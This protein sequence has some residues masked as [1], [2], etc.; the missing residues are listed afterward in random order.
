VLLNIAATD[1]H[2]GDRVFYPQHGVA[3]VVDR[4]EQE[5]GGTR[6]DFWV[7]KLVSG[8]RMF[9]PADNLDDSGIRPLVSRDRAQALL[10]RL[11]TEPE[12]E[13]TSG[14]KER[15]QLYSDKLKTSAPEDY[16]DV[17]H[18]LLHRGESK[19]LSSSE[20]RT[21]NTAR[22]YFATE[23]GTVLELNSEQ[24]RTILES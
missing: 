16:T 18:Q 1:L 22:A 8:G 10:D 13:R 5:V 23:I 14:W 3:E 24:L 11:K 12:E 17:I 20:L 15:A 2:P 21:L 6:Q 9:I 4:I 7:L 19:K